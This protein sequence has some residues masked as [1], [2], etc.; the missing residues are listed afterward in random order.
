MGSVLIERLCGRGAP[1]VV[2]PEARNL[3]PSEPA[4]RS[5]AGELHLSRFDIYCVTNNVNIKIKKI[6]SAN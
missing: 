1:G 4:E 2:G 5:G 6:A 3:K